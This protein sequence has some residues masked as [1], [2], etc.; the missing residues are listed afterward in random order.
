MPMANTK[1]NMI[2]VFI[3]KPRG[4]KK[5]NVPKI[6]TGIANKGMMVVRQFCKNKKFRKNYN[7]RK[8]KRFYYFKKKYIKNTPYIYNILNNNYYFYKNYL[9]NTNK[10]NNFI[11]NSFYNKKASRFFLYSYYYKK[12][13]KNL[14]KN[15]K[16]GL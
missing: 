2:N 13:Y 3:V 15:L 14:F 11:L 16:L 7:L 10:Y 1:P 4:T 8:K 9:F 12:R 6:E 5:I